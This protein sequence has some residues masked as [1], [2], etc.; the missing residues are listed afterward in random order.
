MPFSISA[1][2]KSRPLSWSAISSFEYD[3]DQWY[4][5]YILNEKQT[6]KEMTYGSMIDKRFQDDPTFFPEIPRGEHLQYKIK[7][8]FGGIP[9]VGVPDILSLKDEKLLAD[10]KTGKKL[11]DKKR[12]DETGQL[13]FYLLLLYITHKI[14]P[15]DFSCRIYW[16][17]TCE[18]GDF[19]I[20]LVKDCK[21][22]VFDTRRTMR[23]LLV[24]GER[25]KK[26]VKEME[27]YVHKLSPP[28][29]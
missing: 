16:L 1:L 19:N 7:V 23:D 26:T 17:Q 6:S 9:L 10:L 27:E 3:P 24:F 12:A 14:N 29:L 28:S 2:L 5:S 25:I 15:E 18:T 13:T 4:R 21:V 20:E 11:W 8:F 22:K